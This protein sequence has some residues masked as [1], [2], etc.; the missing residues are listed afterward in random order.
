M[1]VAGII[2]EYNP[3]H[4]GH[5]YQ[6]EAARAAGATHLAVVMSGC[7]VQRGGPACAPAHI[8]AEAAVNSG[9]DLV[10]ELPLP[11]AMARAQTFALGGVRLLD[12]LGCVD[13][14][15]FG[16]ES[17]NLASL[18]EVSRVLDSPEYKE[19]LHSFIAEGVTF[20]AARQKAV[21]KIL[22]EAAAV[23]RQP[24]DTLAIE[25]LR[26]LRQQ[27][28]KMA[29]LPVA[30]RGAAHDA[31]MEEIHALEGFAS[32]SA[33]RVLMAQNDFTA[34]CGYVPTSALNCYKK[35][36]AQG[37]MPSNTDRL[38]H[39]LLFALR[40]MD[41]KSFHALPDISEGLENRLYNAVRQAC[42]LTELYMLTKTK[43][44]T[45]ARIRRL[46]WS[47]CLGIPAQLGQ[48][49]PPYL[50][51][52]AFNE[53]GREILAAASKTAS[54]PISHSLA[55][56]EGKNDICKRFATLEATSADLFALAL[57]SPLPCGMLYRTG[58]YI[59]SRK[60]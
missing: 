17:E 46:V 33:L 36:I 54:I 9:A 7:F 53:R 19:H 42:S 18:Q 1:K 30:R 40:K 6:L 26:A 38:E 52:L 14:L 11:Y 4:N 15:C 5:A 39:A 3:F 8:R 24:N 35:G 59:L 47:A 37:H 27:N 29:P 48:T 56:L 34:L 2:A 20:A 55:H 12:A 21:E 10:L 44:Y 57:P 13:Y 60:P 45:L 41:K 50:R 49:P 16:T 58:P 43:R 51:I 31:S 28:S 25:Y 23:L 32:A 22:G